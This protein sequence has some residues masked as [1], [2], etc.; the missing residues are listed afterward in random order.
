MKKARIVLFIL[1]I[2]CWLFAMVGYFAHGINMYS[3]CLVLT[4]MIFGFL[5]FLMKEDNE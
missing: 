3:S 5:N 4:G 1:M 2:I